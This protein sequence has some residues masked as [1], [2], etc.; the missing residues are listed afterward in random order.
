MVTDRQNL[1]P[2]DIKWVNNLHAGNEGNDYSTP[3]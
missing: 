2:L 1:L 3:A